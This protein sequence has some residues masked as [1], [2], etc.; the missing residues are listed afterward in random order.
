MQNVHISNK[1]GV[2]NHIS[3]FL[4]YKFRSFQEKLY[5]LGFVNTGI[6]AQTSEMEEQEEKFQTDQNTAVRLF[7]EDLIEVCHQ[8]CHHSAFTI[9][10]NMSHRNRQ[11]SKE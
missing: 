4:R 5:N 3:S 7:T 8:R 1:A 2:L 6:N 10:L 11:M 9:F